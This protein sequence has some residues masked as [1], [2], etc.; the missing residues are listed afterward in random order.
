MCFRDTEVPKEGFCRAA[1]VVTRFMPKPHNLLQSR[2]AEAQRLPNLK[3]QNS[4]IG[5]II[6]GILQGLVKVVGG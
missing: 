1:E 6:Q 2:E 5:S 4:S 3:P